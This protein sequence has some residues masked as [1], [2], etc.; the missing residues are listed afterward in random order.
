VHNRL[1][2]PLLAAVRPPAPLPVRQAL[3][4]LDRAVTDDMS[5]AR[6]TA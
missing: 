1:L 2:R 5:D 4:T 3:R 6:M